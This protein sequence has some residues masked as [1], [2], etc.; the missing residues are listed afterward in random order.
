MAFAAGAEEQPQ[1]TQLPTPAPESTEAAGLQYARLDTG[2][3]G[4][5]AEEPL[6][7][8]AAASVSSDDSWTTD[9][10]ESAAVNGNQ[11]W[12][13]S[14]EWQDGNTQE[15]AQRFEDFGETTDFAEQLSES[16]SHQDGEAAAEPSPA[17]PRWLQPWD[18]EQKGSAADSTSGHAKTV[19]QPSSVQQTNSQRFDAKENNPKPLN[20]KQRVKSEPMSEEHKTAILGAM[21]NVKI[22]YVPRWAIHL[23][24]ERW[25]NAVKH[26]AAQADKP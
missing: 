4:D 26:K 1:D 23:E 9:D 12:T 8:G 2:D 5:Q 19:S 22:D 21:K 6:Q 3:A 25:L 15:A 17:D 13:M 18:Q 7:N 14:F 16:A 11:M 20:A 24:E 10:E